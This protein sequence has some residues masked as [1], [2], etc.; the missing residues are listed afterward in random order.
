MQ[1]KSAIGKTK[2]DS[3]FVAFSDAKK[4]RF[5]E[6]ALGLTFAYGWGTEKV[7]TFKTLRTTFRRLATELEQQEIYTATLDVKELC[8]RAHGIDEAVIGALL[9]ESFLLATYTFSKY[10]TKKP[11]VFTRLEYTNGSKE[12]FRGIERGITLAS[13]IHETRE[14]ANTPGGD[15][16]PTHL[17]ESAVRI[18]RG[19]KVRVKI[20]KKKEIEKLEMGALLGV[21]KGSIHEPRFIILEYRGATQKTAK[22]N[23]PDGRG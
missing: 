23:Y 14:L 10:K 7:V 9:S 4:S 8:D 19:T 5:V 17:A 6:R 16:T 18:L 2:S 15:M 21:A 13:A 11:K 1:F 12:F 20:L 22:I 3:T